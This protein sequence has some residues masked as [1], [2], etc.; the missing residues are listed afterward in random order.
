MPTH[1]AISR[2]LDLF[3][4]WLS[5]RGSRAMPSRSDINP[6]DIPLLLPHVMIVEKADDQFRYRLVGSAIVQGIGYDAT[7]V[8]VGSYLI[9]PEAAAEVRAIFQRVYTDAC[10]V[11][12]TGEFIFKS[13]AQFNMSLL[14][15][16]L[17]ED[18]IAVNMSIST[19]ASCFSAAFVPRRGWL[20]GLP[21]KADVVTDIRDAAELEKFCREWEQRCAPIAEQRP[22]DR[23]GY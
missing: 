20:K 16:P 23:R 4:Y 11:F 3:A 19:L 7:G 5:K 9:T 13:G 18:G 21:A 22:A 6:A 14:T 2:H 12:S 15:L 10:P 17:S 1:A 8:T